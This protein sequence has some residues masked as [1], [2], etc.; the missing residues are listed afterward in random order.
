MFLSF[1]LKVLTEEKEMSDRENG[2]VKWFDNKKGYGF[3]SSENGRD[4]FVHFRSIN[5]RGFKSLDEGQ[6]VTFVVKESPKGAQA[7]DVTIVQ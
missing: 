1:I 3:I 2:T 7:E 4:V 5:S 6:K